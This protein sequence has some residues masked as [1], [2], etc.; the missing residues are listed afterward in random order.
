M[1]K[2]SWLVTEEMTG[3]KLDI[4][5]SSTDEWSD[6]EI[7]EALEGHAHNMRTKKVRNSKPEISMSPTFSLDEIEQAR[8]MIEGESDHVEM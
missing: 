6:Q 4:M 5:V 3:K 7:I 2:S 8:T 1:R